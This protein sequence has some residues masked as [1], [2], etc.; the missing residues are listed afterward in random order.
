MLKLLLI[1]SLF[2]GGTSAAAPAAPGK[3][4]PGKAA[5]PAKPPPPAAKYT[6]Y[7]MESFTCEIPGTWELKRDTKK[8]MT[9]KIRK[10]EL[11][12]PRAE[13]APVI[14][15]AAQY[16]K[17]NTTFSDHKDFIARNSKNILGET[18]SDTEK[19]SPVKETS[20][21]GKQAFEFDSEIKEYLHPESKSDASVMIKE[22]FYVIP[23][24]DGFFV[25][26]YYSP[27]S[28]FDKNL[29]VF[30]KLVATFKPL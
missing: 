30:N 25:L 14:I 18:E 7:D 3:A 26:H 13:N 29:P 1:L 5:A 6:R 21:A 11:S 10:L 4:A 15:Y 28:A 2:S 22:K 20:L 23:A 8:E 16:R 27:A 17:G 19:F 9:T 24:K 12:G